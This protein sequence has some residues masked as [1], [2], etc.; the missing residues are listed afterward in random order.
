MLDVILNVKDINNRQ[1]SGRKQK[2]GIEKIKQLLYVEV[3]LI[4]ML[5]RELKDLLQKEFEISIELHI[6]LWYN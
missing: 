4:I 3:I 1:K 6:E 2:K 5:V